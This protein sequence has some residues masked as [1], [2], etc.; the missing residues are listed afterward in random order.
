MTRRVV[1]AG[2]ARMISRMFLQHVS[3]TP[4]IDREVL[5]GGDVYRLDRELSQA[6]ARENR[7]QVYRPPI[8]GRP[9][10]HLEPVARGLMDIT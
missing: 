10:A 9:L 3:T 8:R 1:K 2:Q 5:G 6:L 7:Y 4:G